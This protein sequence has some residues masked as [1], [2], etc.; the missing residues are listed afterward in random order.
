MST[1]QGTSPGLVYNPTTGTQNSNVSGVEQ[2]LQDSPAPA[3]PEVVDNNLV[4]SGR[5]SS[6]QDRSPANTN[7]APTGEQVG[8]IAYQND[9]Q[10]YIVNVIRTATGS[11]LAVGTGEHA[12]HVFG[13]A[14]EGEW[15][16][17]REGPWT[18][19]AAQRT[20]VSETT[21]SASNTRPGSQTSPEGARTNEDCGANCQI[22]YSPA[23][24]RT[25]QYWIK[26]NVANKDRAD[27]TQP[28]FS[29]G[30]E[31]GNTV[32]WSVVGE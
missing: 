20:P 8:Q 10:R 1:L 15:G 27:M 3:R 13:N 18:P 7:T 31:S 17:R 2:S 26:I 24:V 21:S 22:F 6:N 30:F 29:D 9:G 32:R 23:E 16:N 4:G 28:T 25:G 12:G 11:T 19:P 14:T 5:L